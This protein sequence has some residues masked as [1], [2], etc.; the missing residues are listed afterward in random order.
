MTVEELVR[1]LGADEIQQ[2]VRAIA[3]A[4]GQGTAGAQRLAEVLRR[5]DASPRAQTWAM[6]G[7]GQMGRAIAGVVREAVVEKLSDP[8][9]MTRRAAIRT[10]EGLRDVASRDA[11]AALVSDDVVDP[12]AWFDDDCTVAHAAR[13]ALATLDEVNKPG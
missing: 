13:A 10:L 1:E 9:P 4:A 5:P 2:R 8:S 6:I 7:L 12:S 3:W 11:I